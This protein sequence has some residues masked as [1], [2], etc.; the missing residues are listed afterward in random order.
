MSDPRRK[1]SGSPKSHL[2]LPCS[3]L[4]ALVSLYLSN[5]LMG[6]IVLEDIQ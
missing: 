6:L 4:N 2:V 1:H 3:F 5:I